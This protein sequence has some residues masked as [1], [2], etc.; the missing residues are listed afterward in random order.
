MTEIDEQ[1][2]PLPHG[3]QS[4]TKLGGRRALTHSQ[5]KDKQSLQ[6]DVETHYQQRLGAD[7]PQAF[8]KPPT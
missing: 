3:F 2:E 6:Q 8:T 4:L 7:H 5:D 1:H